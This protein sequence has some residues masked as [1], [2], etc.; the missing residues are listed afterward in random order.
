M[1]T[2]YAPEEGSRRQ[3]RRQIRRRDSISHRESCDSSFWQR[4]YV[5]GHP[6]H[7]D[8]D[9]VM[10]PRCP[11]YRRSKS[12]KAL[13]GRHS[14]PGPGPTPTGRMKAVSEPRQTPRPARARRPTRLQSDPPRH[15]D[16]DCHGQRRRRRAAP[17]PLL[18][19]ANAVWADSSWPGRVRPSPP[20][21]PSESRSRS[22]S[23]ASAR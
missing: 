18:L 15:R 10:V 3:S 12:C 19:P 7:H 20:G 5:T 17:R 1:C 14:A 13:E 8:L 16:R 21:A 2:R 9:Q 22:R 23:C 4:T 11:E 6:D